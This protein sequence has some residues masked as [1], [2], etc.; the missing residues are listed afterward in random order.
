MSDTPLPQG[1]VPQSAHQMRRALKASITC[2]KKVPPNENAIAYGKAHGYAF[3]EGGKL[4][5][6]EIFADLSHERLCALFVVDPANS[7]EV[8][9]AADDYA[10]A[11]K[12]EIARCMRE[13]L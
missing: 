13:G 10:A 2:F 8:L 11:F 4:V 6:S 7:A 1:S 9:A 3:F 5:A 12:Q